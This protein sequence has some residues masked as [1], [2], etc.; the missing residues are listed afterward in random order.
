MTG[1][2]PPD[3]FYAQTGKLR[4]LA[5]SAASG[6]GVFAALGLD[7]PEQGAASPWLVWSAVAVLSFAAARLW[8]EASDPSPVLEVFAEGIRDRTFG[9]IP[10]TDVARW[11]HR[12]GMLNPAFGFSLRKGAQPP[13]N[14]A[15]FRL[16]ALMNRLGG[17]PAR[18]YRRKMI[19]GGAEPMAKAFRRH[20][21][22][23]EG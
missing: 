7:P 11:R 16:L 4:L 6:A 13:R 19:R 5:V 23:L 3:A 21:P 10:W 8:R 1:P 17:L 12:G 14:L 2:E 20:A 18:C 22:H 9:E 15:L